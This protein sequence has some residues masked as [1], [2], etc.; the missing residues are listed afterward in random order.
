MLHTDSHKHHNSK[1]K[2]V[3]AAGMAGVLAGAVGVTA[4]ALSDRDIRKRVGKKAHELKS[5]LRDWSSE[6]LQMTDH[7]KT[8]MEDTIKKT[9]KVIE[10]TNEDEPL[11]TEVKMNN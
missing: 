11:K 1:S 5:T 6:K 7:H 2:T 9:E 10:K 8:M 4:L 3:L